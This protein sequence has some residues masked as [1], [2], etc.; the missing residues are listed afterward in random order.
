[1][2]NYPPSIRPNGF[3][4]PKKNNLKRLVLLVISI[5]SLILLLGLIVFFF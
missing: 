2:S 1:M 5:I 4:E 3:F